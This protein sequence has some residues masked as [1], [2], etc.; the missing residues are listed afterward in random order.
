MTREKEKPEVG[1]WP[2]HGWVDALEWMQAWSR[3]D[4][5]DFWHRVRVLFVPHKDQVKD[6]RAFKVMS[7]AEHAALLSEEKARSEKLVEALEHYQG[8]HYDHSGNA[9]HHDQTANTALAAHEASQT[10]GDL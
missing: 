9:C 2:P 3:S 7:V 5:G 1:K 6:G 8:A 10:A 4:P